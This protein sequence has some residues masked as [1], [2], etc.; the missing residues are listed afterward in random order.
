MFGLL[1]E[2]VLKRF[3]LERLGHPDLFGHTLAVMFAVHTCITDP[4]AVELI[5]F[6]FPESLI[7]GITLALLVFLWVCFSIEQLHTIHI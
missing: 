1:D 2:S 7:N 4:V 5:D 3:E 6:D